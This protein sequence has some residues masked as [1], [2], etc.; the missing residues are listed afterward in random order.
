[1]TTI[2][3]RV[4]TLDNK[5]LIIKAEEHFNGLFGQKTE[6]EIYYKPESFWGST[7]THLS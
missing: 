7:F 1:M 5:V 3:Y 6:W 4:T 2:F